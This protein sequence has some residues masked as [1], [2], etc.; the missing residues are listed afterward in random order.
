MVVGY[1]DEKSDKDT[2]AKNTVVVDNTEENTDSDSDVR[3]NTETEN[4]ERLTLAELE[5][6]ASSAAAVLFAFNHA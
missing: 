2:K 1:T 6:A 4:L 3:E 5:S